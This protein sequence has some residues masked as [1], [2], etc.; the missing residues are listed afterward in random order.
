MKNSWINA[1]EKDTEETM[2]LIV[3]VS[4]EKFTLDVNP[5]ATTLH[6]LKVAI[7]QFNGMPVSNH[8][9]FLSHSLGQNDSDLISNLGIQPFSTLTLHGT[10]D[11]I[12]ATSNTVT[13]ALVKQAETDSESES[14]SDDEAKARVEAYEYLNDSHVD[15]K[16]EKMFENDH[17]FYNRRKRLATGNDDQHVCV[18]FEREHEKL[19]TELKLKYELEYKKGLEEDKK[20]MEDEEAHKKAKAMEKEK[21]NKKAKDFDMKSKEAKEE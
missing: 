21:A 3:S 13:E 6:Q 15:D 5:N 11:T 20:F 4:G 14:E 7:Q 18:M 8:R 2:V 12:G 1:S 10:D 17:I 16:I 19:F 9:L